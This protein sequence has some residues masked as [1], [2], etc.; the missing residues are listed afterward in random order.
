VLPSRGTYG[1]TGGPGY[2]VHRTPVTEGADWGFDADVVDSGL[3]P[4]DL[5]ETVIFTIFPCALVL[6]AGPMIGWFSFLPEGVDRCRFLNGFLAPAAL[7]EAGVVD[8]AEVGQLM[9]DINDEDEQI[10]RLVQRGVRS[11]HAA[12]GMLSHKEPAL[13]DFY[14]YLRRALQD[15]AGR[16]AY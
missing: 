7:D 13:A 9:N 1:A 3:L 12:P 8:E 5:A 2:A 15:E 14:A 10:I 6:N 16:P 11:R 4:A